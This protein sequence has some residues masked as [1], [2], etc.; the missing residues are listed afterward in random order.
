MVLKTAIFYQN[1]KP[2]I[3]VIFIVN[4]HAPQLQVNGRDRERRSP[5]VHEPSISFEDT[6]GHDIRTSSH[7]A[8]FRPV[9]DPINPAECRMENC[10]DDFNCKKYGFTVYIYPTLDQNG[11]ISK[12]YQKILESIRRSPY[13]TTDAEKACIK[14]TLQNFDL[15]QIL[16]FCK[17]LI[18]RQNLF[19]N[20]FFVTKFRFF[21][22][23]ISIVQIFKLSREFGFRYRFII[24]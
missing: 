19:S 2:L 12:N 17:I 22:I 21:F 8:T 23:R 6:S 11:P 5:D 9:T 15:T 4:W 13:Y 16:F 14:G 3:L 24:Y 18:F 7:Y 1:F 20:A 10:F